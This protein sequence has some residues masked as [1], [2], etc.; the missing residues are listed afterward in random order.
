MRQFSWGLLLSTSLL[1]CDEVNSFLQ[2]EFSGGPSRSTI[3]QVC[4]RY[5]ACAVFD[6]GQN[7]ASCIQGLE[8]EWQNQSVLESGLCEAELQDC[9]DNT[10]CASFL[11]CDV[12]LCN[13]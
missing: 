2:S 6:E 7:V 1:G 10:E 4:E 13:I 3:E 11:S 5:E 8:V 9:L 12:S